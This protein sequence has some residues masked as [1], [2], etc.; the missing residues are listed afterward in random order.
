M[1]KK[2]YQ[3][4]DSNIPHD[5]P[6]NI[7]ELSQSAAE[8]HLAESYVQLEK[9][10][11]ALSETIQKLLKEIESREDEITH[12]KQLLTSFNSQPSLTGL[13][14]VNPISDEELIADIQLRKL[15]EKAKI[16]ELTLDETRRYDLFVKNKRL[17]Q[18]D[19]TTING[20]KVDSNI[21][22]KSKLLELASK[23]MKSEEK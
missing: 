18:G 2:T 4:V 21:P 14:T 9:K 8:K 10:A 15:K 17:A 22:N 6:L 20:S 23:K 1:K 3:S 12:L 7:H 5:R 19:A 11:I 13:V 16:S